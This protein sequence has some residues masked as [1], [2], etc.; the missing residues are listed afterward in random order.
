MAEQGISNSY[1]D[2]RYSLTQSKL[3]SHTV[4]FVEK[5][6]KLKEVIQ[7][8]SFHL[9][10]YL[11]HVVQL[12]L[13]SISFFFVVVSMKTK[14]IFWIVKIARISIFYY[15]YYFYLMREYCLKSNLQK[16]SHNLSC[17]NISCSAITKVHLWQ[18]LNMQNILWEIYCKFSFKQCSLMKTWRTDLLFFNG[19]CSCKWLES[20]CFCGV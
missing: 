19:I 8:S 3:L 11:K 7:M 12:T 15:Y 10:Q 4:G 20:L 9:T 17:K 2:F 1:C 6:P 16:L 18:Q 14:K 13:M 5:Q